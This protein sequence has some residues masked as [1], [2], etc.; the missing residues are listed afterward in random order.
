MLL[1][2]LIA[3]QACCPHT[4]DSCEVIITRIIDG[5]TYV[6]R[7]NDEEYTIRLLGLDCFETRHGKRLEKQAEKAGIS[8]DSAM[9]L[10]KRAKE[11]A[12]N[13][14]LNQKV[15]II[16]DKHERNFDSYNRLLRHVIVR[17]SSF[18]N[19]LENK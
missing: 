9:T 10:G 6:F 1:Q 18:I 8:I 19:I 11:R 13:Y 2:L 7:Q 17:D 4:S 16:R 3:I 12:I 14:L 5:D 15:K